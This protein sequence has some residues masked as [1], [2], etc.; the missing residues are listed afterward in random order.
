MSIA[1]NVWDGV[2]PGETVLIEH[3]STTMPYVGLWQLINWGKEKGYQVVV[4]DVLDTLY[5]YKAQMKL[6]GLDAGILDDVKVIKFGGRLEVGQVVERLHI[7]ELA[8]REQEYRRIF[9]SLSG[10]AVVNP[11][12]GIEK[13]FLLA[14]SKREVLSTVNEI[15]SSVGD[16]RRIAFYFVNTDLLKTA[17]PEALPLLEELA[18]MIVKVETKGKFHQSSIV[19]SVNKELLGLTFVLP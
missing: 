4:D 7:K 17:T 11:V 12:L 14:E 13:L 10:G 3:S 15:L 5:L 8:I 19:K 16:E 1:K 9:D 2:K 18:S 6:A